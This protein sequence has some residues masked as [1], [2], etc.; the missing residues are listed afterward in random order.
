MTT[1]TQVL[2]RISPVDTTLA[3]TV[4]AHLDNLTKP[5]GSLGRL[6]EIA[7]RYCLAR[8]ATQPEMGKKVIYTF[9]ADHGVAAEGVSAF[10]PEVTVQMVKNMLGGGAAVN[11]L[12]RQAGAEVRV[13]DIGV[14][15]PLDDVA[16]LLR[17]KIAPGTG[18]IARGPAMT[19]AQCRQAMEVGMELAAQAADEGVTL[20][21]TGEMGIGN[22]TP[23]AALFAALLPCAVE[24]A[25]GLGTGITPE[26]LAHK[27]Q[28][29]RRAL[30]ANAQDLTDPIGALSAVGG[31]EIAGICG[32]ILGAAARRVPTVVDGFISTAAALTAWKLCPEV[33][34][35]LF[36]SHLS[37][38]AGH[39]QFFAQMGVLPLL[40][41]QMRLG[42]GTGAALAMFMIEAAVKTYREMATF[43]T[44]GVARKESS[45]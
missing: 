24:A 25:T 6:E 27:Q 13:V 32:L 44:A 12:A 4:Q 37:A 38:E 20:L 19:G 5:R 30:E 17:Q 43:D 29:V 14:N 42:E 36:F 45:S 8:D 23:S 31:F 9:A 28:I 10:P 16:G 26:R 21:G 22:T 18:N 1:F 2:G 35:Y 15:S 39:R 40:D 11:V 3:A 34:D 41:L 33:M 7:L